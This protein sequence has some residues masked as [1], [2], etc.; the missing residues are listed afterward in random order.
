MNAPYRRIQRAAEGVWLLRGEATSTVGDCVRASTF[1]IVACDSAA[2]AIGV[3]VASKLLA[4][5][6]FCPFVRGGVGAIASQA[7]LNPY[8]GYDGLQ[9]LAEGCAPAETLDDLLA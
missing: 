2:G 1:S 4:V 3:A 6:A 9:K 5:G 8:L 7:Y